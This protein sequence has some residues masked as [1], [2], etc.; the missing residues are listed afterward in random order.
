[1]AWVPP[2]TVSTSTPLC[3][4]MSL[5]F[6]A[7]ERLHLSFFLPQTWKTVIPA[8]QAVMRT[9]RDKGQHIRTW[10][11]PTDVG[12]LSFTLI[13]MFCVKSNTD[14]P[15]RAQRTTC[16]CTPGLCR[17]S[18]CGTTYS[19]PSRRRPY[20]PSPVARIG[21][22][23]PI[24]GGANTGAPPAPNEISQGGKRPIT[25]CREEGKPFRPSP[26]NTQ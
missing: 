8:S 11:V 19:S 10:L 16:C 12:S 24:K 1:M 5:G 26:P 20:H 22:Q 23:T 13:H 15:P 7:G 25:T 6:G 4:A 9:E 17:M 18:L 14:S 3:R 21:N 2:S